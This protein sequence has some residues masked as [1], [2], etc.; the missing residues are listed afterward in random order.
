MRKI[1][2][3]GM[4]I[5]KN[6]FQLHGVDEAEQVVL[7][8]TLRR[9]G[10]EPFFSALPATVIGM[11]ACGGAHHWARVLQGLGHQV[12]LLPPQY[13]KPYVKRGKND[14]ADAAAICEAMSRPSMRFVTVRSAENQA[15]LM[16]HGARDL[17]IKQRT[18]LVNAIRGQAAELGITGAKGVGR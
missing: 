8:R 14:T 5:S 15:A 18:M 3:I 17:L 16:V 4:D 13:V 11:E 2:R 10:L 9:G 7:Q 12:R 6:V 1:I